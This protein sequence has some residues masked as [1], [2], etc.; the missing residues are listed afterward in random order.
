[1]T[2]KRKTLYMSKSKYLLL[3][4]LLLAS[5]A[6][7]APSNFKSRDTFQ[8]RTMDRARVQRNMEYNQVK[9][10]LIQTQAMVDALQVQLNQATASER[11]DRLKAA[12]EEFNLPRSTCS[13]L[14]EALQY[15]QKYLALEE[16]LLELEIST[17]NEKPSLDTKRKL[18]SLDEGAKALRIKGQKSMKKFHKQ[19]KGDELQ[20]VRNWITIS[21]G[22]LIRQQEQAQLAATQSIS[23]T[24]QGAAG[25]SKA[26]SLP[27]TDAAKPAQPAASSTSQP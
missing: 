1:M 22:M 4:L 6:V 18:K 26:T 9:D 13:S 14:N 3:L 15:S 7:S 24:A 11:E 5:P 27:A 20:S 2:T 25:A 23:N 12:R 10:M 16:E 8:Q 21:E 17:K 19:L